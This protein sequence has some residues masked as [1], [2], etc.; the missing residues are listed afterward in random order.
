MQKYAGS[1]EQRLKIRECNESDIGTYFLL[2]ACKDD[3]EYVTS[4]ELD[5]KVIKGKYDLHC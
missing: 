4:N 2:V 3:M 1:N 5:L